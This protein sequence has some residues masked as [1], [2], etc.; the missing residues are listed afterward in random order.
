MYQYGYDQN[1]LKELI[2]GSCKRYGYGDAIRAVQYAA[3]K[4]AGQK[5][6]NG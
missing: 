5:R 1:K 4:H 2:E 6:M 3:E